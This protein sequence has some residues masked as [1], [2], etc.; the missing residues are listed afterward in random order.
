[1]GNLVPMR[2]AW[3]A[4]TAAILATLLGGSCI[5]RRA[6]RCSQSP[7]SRGPTAIRRV[8]GVHGSQRLTTGAIRGGARGAAAVAAALQS[9]DAVCECAEAAP[10]EPLFDVQWS[11]RAR[12]SASSLPK[13]TILGAAPTG[14]RKFLPTHRAY[15]GNL[16]SHT[17]YSDGS[18]TPDRAFAHARDVAGLDFLALTEHNHRRA[19]TANG[20]RIAFHPS[21]YAGPRP[22]AL[23]PVA[24]RAT[25]D[26]HFVALYGQ[27]YSS[28]S[29]GNHV[30]VFDVGA[31]IDDSEVSNGSFDTLLNTWLPNNLDS[32][33]L[34]PLLQ[35]NH[36]WSSS[37]PND[38]E[39][40]RDDFQSDAEWIKK[41]DTHAQLIEIINGPSHRSGTGL[42]P[43]SISDREYRRYLNLGFHLAPTANQ[44]NHFRTWGSITDARTAVVSSELSKRGLLSA[45][46]ARNVYATLDKNLR[47]IATV[48]GVLI[49][50]VVAG[51]ALGDVLAIEIAIA[52]DDAPAAS[53]AVEV[54][55]DEIGG[56]HS[57]LVATYAGLATTGSSDDDVWE[58]PNLTYDGWDYLYLRVV[59]EDGAG[60]PDLKAWLAP[61]WFE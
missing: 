24:D 32:E 56:N 45:L 28:I 31:V 39:Y 57:R 61:V 51:K 41:L 26:G 60:S 15:F 52:D 10:D 18:D 22:D 2:L 7:T 44:D 20:M 46:R 21:R 37:S 53:Y 43:Q 30:N 35:L 34:P 59:A 13:P 4:A 1:M 17:G 36:P 58:L 33:G 12:L 25:D 6:S 9:E 8:R 38:I 27:E 14:V 55:A 40:G 54:F 47:L 29:K 23:L 5:S 49:G 50:G 16:H 3:L 48:D 11:G 19:G 42:R